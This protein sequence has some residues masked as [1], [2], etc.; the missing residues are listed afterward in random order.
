M[1]SILFKSHV[2]RHSGTGCA[3]KNTQ[4]ALENLSHSESTRAL[5]QS[6]STLRVLRHSSTRVLRA[7]L[8][9]RA[10]KALGLLDTQWTQALGHSGNWA[11][12]ALRQLEHLATWALGHLGTRGTLFSRLL[13]SLAHHRNVASLSLFYMYY[14][15]RSSSELA[16]LVPLPYCRG[17]ST[18]YSDRLHD[19]SVTSLRC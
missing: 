19:F 6:E 7:H 1:L 11:L 10:L 15:G 12:K 16:Q 13:E 17:R 14:F 18:H 4:R 2:I 3:F 9:T 5:G 8:G